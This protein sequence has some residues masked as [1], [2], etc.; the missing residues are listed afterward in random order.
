MRL[1]DRLR[2]LPLLVIVAFMSFVIR[3]G[4]MTIGISHSGTAYAQHEVDVETPPLDEGHVAAEAG[5]S[6]MAADEGA[7]T[8]ENP[9]DELVNE[10]TAEK[11]EWKD[12]VDTDFVYSGVQEEL[13]RDLM[14]RR[15]GL[16][17]QEKTL[18][19]REALLQAAEREVD[20]KLRELEVIRNEIQELLQ[21]Q[22]DE[23]EARINSLVKIY[24]GM[25]AKDAARIFN[26]L[27]TEVLLNVMSRM[28]ERKSA[29]IL[30]EMDAERARSITI[31]LAQ[32][33]RLPTLPPR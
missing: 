12:A 8:H 1:Y 9:V 13:Y 24:E 22:S 25:K 33:K 18:A 3:I 15:E 26:T 19:M 20:Q 10:D 6:D 27:D 30:A 17:K 28:S 21:R 31:L 2:V 14:R 11:I 16:D 32:Q 29:P 7:D 5:G 4:D 23:E